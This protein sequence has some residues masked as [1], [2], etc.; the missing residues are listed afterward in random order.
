MAARKSRGS[1]KIDPLQAR[2]LA[3]LN[4]V[5]AERE[6]S[7]EKL[8]ELAGFTQ[9]HVSR[10]LAGRQPETAFWVIARLAMALGVSVDWLI[11]GPRPAAG[12][13]PSKPPA[14]ATG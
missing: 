5:R 7:Q 3:R 14:S 12:E 8:A 4:E 1:G 6:I 2:V 13:S 10:I 9:G 11:E